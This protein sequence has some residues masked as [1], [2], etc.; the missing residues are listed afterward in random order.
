[1][2]GEGNIL[3]RDEGI[4]NRPIVFFLISRGWPRTQRMDPFCHSSLMVE[5]ENASNK[6]EVDMSNY[7]ARDDGVITCRAHA[8]RFPW[9]ACEYEKTLKSRKESIEAHRECG[10]EG[11]YGW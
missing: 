9:A 6:Q 2:I 11:S 5:R 3:D 10:G 1:M 4:Y 7:K 8:T